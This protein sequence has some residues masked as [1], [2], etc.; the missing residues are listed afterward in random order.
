MEP[1][2]RV[3]N[4]SK[5]FPGVQALSGVSLHVMPGEVLSVIGENGAGKSTLMKILAGVQ[6]PDSGRL[7]WQGREVRFGGPSE[8]IAA[9]ISLIHQELNLA[10]NLSIAENLFLGRLPSR[11]GIVQPGQMR[12]RA[13]GLLEQVGLEIPSSTPVKNLSIAQ[14]QMVEIAKSLAT[15]ASLIIMDE[16]TSSLSV[17]ESEKLFALIRRLKAQGVAIVY[18]SHRLAEVAE[19]S[20]RVEVLRDASYATEWISVVV[21]QIARDEV[22]APVQA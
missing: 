5:S 19:L 3:E 14:R 4:V 18:I 12:Q 9:G 1:L 6:G 17:H 7:V 20:D 13:E 11:W 15:D 21:R 8:A 16:P 10:E 22:E 2:L